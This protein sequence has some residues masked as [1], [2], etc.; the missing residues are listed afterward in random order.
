MACWKRDDFDG[1][2]CWEYYVDDAYTRMFVMRGNGPGEPQCW[3]YPDCYAGEGAQPFV[4]SLADAK[5]HGEALY[6]L[7]DNPTGLRRRS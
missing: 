2:E 7:A 3:V 5:L 1:T 6:A 4:G